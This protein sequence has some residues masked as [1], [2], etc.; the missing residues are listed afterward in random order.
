VLGLP[1]KDQRKALRYGILG[2]FAFRITATV[3]AVYMIQLWW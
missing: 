1:R 2:A 3:F